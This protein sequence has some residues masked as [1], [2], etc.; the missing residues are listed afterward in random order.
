MPLS[1]K[2]NP[3]FKE[4]DSVMVGERLVAKGRE[5]E[6]DCCR[7]GKFPRTLA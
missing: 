1:G 2:S 5:K 4:E 3:W 7:L 6:T